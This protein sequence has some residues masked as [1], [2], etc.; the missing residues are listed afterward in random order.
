MFLHLSVSHSVHGGGS[1]WVGTPHP[2]QVH[3]PG[4]Y[5]PAP[6]GRYIPWTGI[7]PGQVHPPCH[8][9][10]WD[11][12]NKRAV[13]I[14][15][16]PLECILVTGESSEC[17]TKCETEARTN[18]DHSFPCLCSLFAVF[19]CIE[20]NL[21][22]R[23]WIFLLMKQNTWTRPLSLCSVSSIFAVK[24]GNASLALFAYIIQSLGKSLCKSLI[25]LNHSCLPSTGWVFGK[26]YVV[27]VIYVT[28][29]C[30]EI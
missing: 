20:K 26:A 8:S 5:T 15:L 17:E 19:Q 30:V 9:A 2:G 28:A 21:F 18:L 3:T 22:L 7:P 12:V 16:I 27:W 13:R 25:H 14:P 23:P 10:C 6:P 4:R 1:T 24:N 11:T 29:F